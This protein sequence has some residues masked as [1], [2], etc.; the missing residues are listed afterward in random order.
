MTV[1]LDIHTATHDRP[2]NV[3]F[4]ANRPASR[5]WAAAIPKL[6]T[7]SKTSPSMSKISI[8]THGFHVSA[9]MTRAVAIE[10]VDGAH[11]IGVA[12]KPTR[13]SAKRTAWRGSLMKKTKAYRR[14]TMRSRR[15]D[16]ARSSAGS[17]VTDV[18]RVV[19]RGKSVSADDGAFIN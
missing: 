19:S 14:A 4:A 18:R 15:A 10:I 16:S 8:A 5:N 9:A 12:R 17:P 11:R 7:T 2:T 3:E 6:P 13:S 1:K